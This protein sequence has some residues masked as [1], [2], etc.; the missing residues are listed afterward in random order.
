MKKP[1]IK[2]GAFK[3][4]G[5]EQVAELDDEQVLAYADAKAKH[6]NDE[7]RI[8][9]EKLEK[10]ETEKASAED[11]EAV[12]AEMREEQIK[13]L[14]ALNS[15]LEKHGLA[16]NKLT[17]GTT[18]VN[19]GKSLKDQ[20]VEK[21]DEL[22]KQFE[23][24][25]NGFVGV[26]VKAAGTMT[27]ATN[28]SG[29]NIPVEDR[30]PGL[31]RIQRRRPWVLDNI[32]SGTTMS[33][34][35][36]WVDQANA[37]GGAG[38]TAEGALKNQ[39]DFDLVVSS[40]NI[41]KRTVYIKVSD[42]MLDDID[43]LESEINTELMELLMLD[44]D[45]QLLNGDN[46]ALNLNGIIPQSTAW[47]AGS[48]AG[49]VDGANNWDVLRTGVTQI[50]LAN[51]EAT[52]I[53]M[54][55]ED[56]LSMELTKGTDGHYVLPP[57]TSATGLEVGAVP[58][59]KNTGIAAGSFLIMDGARSKAFIRSNIDIR[60]GWENDDFTKN[61]VT[62]LAEVRLNNRIKENDKTAFVTGDFATAK[63]ALETP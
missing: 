48:L 43:Y 45:N 46:L 19:A 54:N 62:I 56:V 53:F 42:E 50:E 12:K 14:K 44:V 1:W 61:L 41:K 39:A 47:S 20:L 30:E 38:G 52:V 27:F 33:N 29:G 3:M 34:V 11:I 60:V 16:I 23:E 17:R 37:D 57:F 13:Q 22:K 6:Y 9:S 21:K 35:V 58:I 55:P 31:G 51:H 32:A 4:L 63:A 7:N 28:V 8:L 10:L 49:T 24:R 59:K 36:S 5:K 18:E 15:V 25:K 26:T 40:V 2:D